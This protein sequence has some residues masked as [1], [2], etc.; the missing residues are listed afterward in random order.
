ME[1]LRNMVKSTLAKSSSSRQEMGGD[2][3]AAPGWLSHYDIQVVLLE[4]GI[5]A[6]IFV[7]LA[8]LHPAILVVAVVHLV[9]IVDDALEDFL[10]P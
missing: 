1:N 2:D 8:Q 9:A 6:I 5:E 10:T 4:H 3:G 7:V